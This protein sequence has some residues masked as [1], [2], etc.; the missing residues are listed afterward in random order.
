MVINASFCVIL[1]SNTNYN[2]KN[3][4][5]EGKGRGFGKRKLHEAIMN[6]FKRESSKTFN[7][8][9]ISKEL[10]I[11]T[12]GERRLV[13]ETLYELK[14][15]GKISEEATGLFKYVQNSAYI[16]GVVDMTARG[17][18]YIVSD[19]VKEDIFVSQ[20][21]LHHALNGDEVKVLVFARKKSRQA[22][23]EVI[24][25]ISRKKET[26]VGILEISRNFAFLISS[27]K[28]MPYDIFLPLNKL[29]GAKNGDKAIA[30][31][32][33]WPK[34]QKNPV[35]EV[36]TVLGKPGDNETE[37]HAILA[38]YELPYKFS[39]EVLKAADL[40]DDTITE[41]EISRRRDYREVITFT[42]DPHDAKDFDDALSL[43]KLSNGNWEIGVH[44]ADVSHY[45]EQGSLLDE[46]A[47]Q[48]ATS[49]YLVDRVVPMLPERLSN[50]VCSLRPNEEKLTFSA[51]FEMDETAKVI[52]TWIGRTVINSNK[53]FTYEEAQELIEGGE[54]ELKEEILLL[55]NLAVKLREKR[56]KKGA[57]DFNKSEVKFDIDENGKPLRVYFKRA[58]ESNKLIEEFM[59]LANKYVAM[60]VGKV[61]KGTKAKT[62]VYRIHDV[63]SPDKLEKFNNF[64]ARFG[65]GIQTESRKGVTTSMNELLDDVKDK[66]EQNLLET[67]AVR[68]MA[69]AEYSTANIGHY[70]LAFDYYSH[71]TSPIRRYPDIMVH[72]LIAEYQ[73]RGKSVEEN[74]Y[75]KMCKHCSEMENIAANA[76]RSSIKYKQVEFMSDKL[77]EE[78]WGTI[79]GVTEWGI[80]VELDE[81]K[82]E[83]MISIANLEDD[84]YEFDEDNFCIR[85]RRNKK[86]Y[87]LGDHINIRVAKANLI[88]K[89]LDFE[90]V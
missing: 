74:R 79:S 26:F 71:F 2:M 1:N 42:I 9:Q 57:I 4:K 35:G 62:F 75:E 77:G 66:P 5:R 15:E 8:R 73:N 63:P 82:C 69:K 88:A 43:R 10:K 29:N 39:E 6:V 58:K 83:G 84:Y 47:Y 38:E 61:D 7:Y 18:A 3:K 41:Q 14:E 85:G 40:I 68:T 27:S 54:G 89:Q 21:N 32:T 65:Y 60:S 25:I 48:R 52:N 30:R 31:I 56:F 59:L 76:E 81:N 87:Q 80:Y 20:I 72:R 50:G 55:N 44:I 34:N 86:E 78:F 49:V 13:F 90:L 67:L 46:E 23:G 24:E 37:M 16:I 17:T 53:R 22:E 11:K 51:I 64:I 12:D 28:Q 19:D 36:I 70:G 33:E 45:V